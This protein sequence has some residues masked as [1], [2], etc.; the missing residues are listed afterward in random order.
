[1]VVTDPALILPDEQS[2]ALWGPD[3]AELG[4]HADYGPVGRL[5]RALA[6]RTLAGGLDDEAE[7]LLARLAAGARVARLPGPAPELMA[8]G[9]DAETSGDGARPGTHEQGARDEYA[10]HEHG[11][12]EHAGHSEHQGEGDDGGG[13]H[14]MMAIVGEPSADGLVME[15]LELTHGPFGTVLPGGLE[16]GVRLDGDV[17][18]ECRVR[19]RL[20]NGDPREE[21]TTGP[22]PPDLLAHAAW[23]AAIDRAQGRPADL[24]AVERERALSHV[25]WLRAFARALGDDRLA[26]AAAAAIGALRTGTPEAGER[27]AAL[28]PLLVRRTVRGRLAGRGVLDAAA[29]EAHGLQGPIARAAGLAADARTADPAYRA[30]G[31]TPAT[32]EDGDALARARVRLSEARDALALADRLP[33][34]AEGPHPVEGPRGPLLAARLPAGWVLAARGA[35]EAR[36]AGGELV[37]GLEWGAALVVLGSL[38]LSPWWV[39]PAPPERAGGHGR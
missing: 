3:P 15:D 39:G 7:R 24:R 1:M 10:A 25:A 33:A 27:L 2:W 37:V 13:G 17:V 36:R 4:L 29:V 38:D 18:A 32:G 12:H 11:G 9:A 6:P 30:L 21:S 20:R 5:T 23:R 35:E 34:A 8:D 22:V 26:A 14:D 28:E 31:F 19:A 16:L